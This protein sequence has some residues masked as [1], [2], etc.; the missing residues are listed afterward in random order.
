[1]ELLA[2]YREEIAK[3]LQVDQMNIKQVQMRLPAR[4]H[5]WLGRLIDAKIKL[6]NLQQEKK[7]I[8]IELV[9]QVKKESPV[10]LTTSATDAAVES[11]TKMQQFNTK[12]AEVEFIIE[13][14][15]KVEKIMGSMHWEIKNIIQI[16]ELE[17]GK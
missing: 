15:E 3:E 17:S 13:Y 4:K 5:V 2:K 7:R 9:Q 12:I 11:S 10:T 16:L 8:K 6:S 14:L 1:M